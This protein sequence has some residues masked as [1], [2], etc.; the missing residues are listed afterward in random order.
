MVQFSTRNSLTLLSILFLSACQTVPSDSITE[1]SAAS[2]MNQSA[3]DANIPEA[4]TESSISEEWSGADPFLRARILADMLYEASR[5]FDDNRLLLPTGDN[6][7]DRYMEV[8]SIVPDN[9]VALAGIEQIV[10]RYVSMANAAIRVGQFDNAQSYLDRASSI[11]PENANIAEAR[12]LLRTESQVSRDYFPLDPLELDRKSLELMS[13][14][15]SIAEYVR[16][17]QATF[18]ITAR[19]DAE[20]R[21]IYQIMREATGG[22]RLRGNIALGNRPTIQVNIP[23]V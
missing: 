15:G 8:L 22:Y 6:A 9:Q 20:G 16:D 1:Q 21:W 11:N 14:L 2:D 10:E 13:R 3:L 23:Q 18:L 7:Y 4:G 5:A 12:R 19:T 17:Q